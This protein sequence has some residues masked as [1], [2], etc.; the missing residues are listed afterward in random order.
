MVNLKRSTFYYQMKVREADDK[1]AELKAEIRSVFALHKGRYGYRRVS[2][3]VR[4]QGNAISRNTVQKLM[5]QLGLKSMVRVKKYVSFKGEIGA[6]APNA[7]NRDFNAAAPNEKWTTDVTEFKVPNGKVFLSTVMDLCTSE[8]IAHEIHT[9][10]SLGLVVRM[11]RSAIS[12]LRAGDKPVFHSDQG[13]Q[14]RM[15]RY[16]DI[17][18]ENGL[19]QSMSRKGNCLDNAAMESFFAIL[20]SE[21]FHLNKF[22]SSEQLRV[23]LNEYIDYYNH[24]RIKSK[25]GGLSPVQY[26]AK[27]LAQQK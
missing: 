23:G 6:A 14:Y 3:T 4:H 15:T 19:I 27:L 12:K 24:T 26:K 17:L 13:W 2:D 7:L 9:R 16:R 5:G 25:L 21:Y 1:Y 22:E 10:P 20:K 8:I 11:A 18:T